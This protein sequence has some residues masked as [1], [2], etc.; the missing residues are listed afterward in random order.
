MPLGGVLHALDHALFLQDGAV[1]LQAL[2][3]L[4]VVI[5]V[6]LVAVLINLAL[7]LNQVLDLLQ[8]LLLTPVGSRFACRG[9]RQ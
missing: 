2:Y 7:L 9:S 8:A 4:D 6:K 3:H 1:S 5:G